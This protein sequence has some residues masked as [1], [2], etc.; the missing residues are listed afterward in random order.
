MK[1]SLLIAASAVVL[2]ACGA[3][4]GESSTS[5]ASAAT[6]SAA[7]TGTTSTASTTSTTT[8]PDIPLP[9]HNACSL[10]VE[11]ALP[12]GAVPERPCI[13]P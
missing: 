3:S 13:Q 6:T 9:Q 4:P 8:T 7:T 10:K 1:N 2:C 5:T 12:A 11:G